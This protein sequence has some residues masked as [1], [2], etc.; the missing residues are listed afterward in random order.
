MP[1]DADTPQSVTLDIGDEWVIVAC[2]TDDEGWPAAATVSVAVTD[3]AGSTSAPTPVEDPAGTW[4][5]RH[6]ITTP[7]RYLAVITS[8][9]V[10]VGAT[11]FTAWA[12]LPTTAEGLPTTSDCLEYLRDTSAT[13]V[14]VRDALTAEMAAQRSRCRVPAV[15]PPDLR[16]S[17]L[18]RVA[19]NLAARGV[20]LTLFT[21]FEGGG[22][23]TRV[24]RL[25]AEIVRFEGPHRR[26]KVG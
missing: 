13:D 12:A 26:R 24:P 5:A 7:G 4:T 1:L 23:S 10:T 20:P 22:T 14:E 17:L 3:P 11:P 6:V 9:G 21:S 18:R 25:D 19:R 2:A 16:Q 15:Y 8:V